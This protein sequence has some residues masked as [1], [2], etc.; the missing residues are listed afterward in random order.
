MTDS[1]TQLIGD[2]SETAKDSA[3]K[4]NLVATL[5]NEIEKSAEAVTHSISSLQAASDH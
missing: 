1:V 2:T 5:M 4:V 3:Q